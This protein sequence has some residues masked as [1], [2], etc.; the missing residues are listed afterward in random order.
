M[1]KEDENPAAPKDEVQKQ[2]APDAPPLSERLTEAEIEALRRNQREAFAYAR[3]A[4][5]PT[6]RIHQAGEIEQGCAKA[7][8]R[9]RRQRT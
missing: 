9:P 1:Q 5:F 7:R 6:A 3:E 2:P 8:L 4:F